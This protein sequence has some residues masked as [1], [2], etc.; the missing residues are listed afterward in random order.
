[1]ERMKTFDMQTAP[2]IEH[3]RRLGRFEEVDGNEPVDAV[4]LAIEA[5]LARLRGERG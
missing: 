4:V 5:A 2:V 1:V 3:Y